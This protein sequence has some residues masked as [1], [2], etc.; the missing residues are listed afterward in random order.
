MSRRTLAFVVFALALAA[1]CVR[2]GVWQLARLDERR[3]RNALVAARLA[4]PATGWG[5]AVRDTAQARYRRVALQGRYDHAREVVHTSRVRDGAPGVHVL[6]PLHLADG[7]IVLVNRGWVYAADG[8]TVDLAL[9]PEGDDAVVEGFLEAY[10]HAPGAVATPSQ[11]RG[12]RVLDRDS[13]QARIG[14]ALAPFVVVQQR[15][16]ARPDSVGRLLR[17]PPPALGEGSHRSYAIQWFAF[18]AI[19]V[20]GVL[21]V[22]VRRAP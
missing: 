17:V 13:L 18:A 16:D 6:T 10:V 1:G 2:L 8:M 11:P 21:A 5:E 12:V 20:L 9:W 14:T 19:A 3:A 4:A 15:P 22:V 7:T